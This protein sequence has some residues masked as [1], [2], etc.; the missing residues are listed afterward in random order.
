[1]YNQIRRSSRLPAK[2]STKQDAFG[3]A[4]N[5]LLLPF[6]GAFIGTPADGLKEDVL[7]KSTNQAGLS[8]RQLLQAG[9]TPFAKS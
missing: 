8:I 9:A 6:A 3:A 7:V 5:D 4:I 1:M 2:E